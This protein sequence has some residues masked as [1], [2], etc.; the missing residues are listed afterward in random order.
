MTKGRVSR[1]CAPVQYFPAVFLAWRTLVLTT[2]TAVS[3]HPFFARM[4]ARNSATISCDAL[5][6]AA[7]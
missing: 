4:A 5:I 6:A 1:L 2:V 3:L 7:C